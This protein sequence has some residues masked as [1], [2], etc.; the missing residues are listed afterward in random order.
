[1]VITIRKTIPS[2]DWYLGS[3]NTTINLADV[4]EITINTKNTLRIIRRLESLSTQS[5]L[6]SDKSRN[7]ILDLKNI[8]DTLKIRGWVIDDASETA[9][10]KA[11]K[12]RA[13]C[14]TGQGALTSLIIENVVFDSSTQE[15]FFLLLLPLYCSSSNCSLKLRGKSSIYFFC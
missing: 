9:W 15:V 14:T 3:G 12:L 6:D 13:M 1:M 10:N 11:W 2:S 8:T 5:S 7:T 4:S